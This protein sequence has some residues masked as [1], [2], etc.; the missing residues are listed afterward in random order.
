[1]STSTSIILL[2]YFLF[3]PLFIGGMKVAHGTSFFFYFSSERKQSKLIS[4]SFTVKRTL[5]ARN[6]GQLPFWVNDFYIDDARCQGYS[7]TVLN[8]EGFE[9]AANASKKVDIA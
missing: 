7:F 2:L 8:C 6:T 5:T 4:P 1:M 9:L 3:I